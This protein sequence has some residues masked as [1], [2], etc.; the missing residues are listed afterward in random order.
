MALHIIGTQ[1]FKRFNWK[2]TSI[3]NHDET[4]FAFLLCQVF[5]LSTWTGHHHIINEPMGNMTQT[6]LKRL[7]LQ[8]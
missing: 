7:W 4:A 2:I 6:E 3:P 8:H 1:I 5:A